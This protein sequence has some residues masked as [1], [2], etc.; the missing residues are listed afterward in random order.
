MTLTQNGINFICQQFGLNDC[1][2]NAGL[3][4]F[5]TIGGTNYSETGGTAQ[6]VSRLASGLVDSVTM[7]S[8]ARGTFTQ[9]DLNAANEGIAVTLQDAQNIALHDEPAEEQY[10]YGTPPISPEG[11]NLPLFLSMAMAAIGTF[12][13]FSK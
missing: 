13:S 10:C 2:V 12:L 1:C 3:S 7:T 4:W 5:Y 9:A 6:V 11:N 8:P